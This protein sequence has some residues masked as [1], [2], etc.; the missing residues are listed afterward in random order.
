MKNKL[1]AVIF[2]GI[3]LC[4][5]FQNT[6]CSLFESSGNGDIL[7]QTEVVTN[8]VLPDTPQPNFVNSW[9][10]IIPG[11][12]TKEDV[13]KA[14][15]KPTHK[16]MWYLPNSDFEFQVPEYTYESLT[17]KQPWVCFDPCEGYGR[18]YFLEGKVVLILIYIDEGLN[19]EDVTK[20]MGEPE[21]KGSRLADYP[22]PSLRDYLE[23]QGIEWKNKV[24][25]WSYLYP[26][27]GITF[28][29]G[30]KWDEDIIGLPKFYSPTNDPPAD[31]PLNAVS[32]F[33]P[34]SMDEYY[35]SSLIDSWEKVLIEKQD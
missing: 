26:S 24:S 21:I 14:L 4:L 20:I 33:E 25:L 9:L 22:K 5:I 16:D 3:H 30:P 35:G 28:T 2:L 31:M 6:S 12:S 17:N 15:G 11:E 13:V 7:I 19:P 10:T 23:E 1:V 34:M 8:T 29:F 18:I 27:S 32:M